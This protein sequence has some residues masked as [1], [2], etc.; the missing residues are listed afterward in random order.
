M[1]YGEETGNFRQ[2]GRMTDGVLLRSAMVKAAQKR[3][4][5]SIPSKFETTL[6]TGD[7]EKNAFGNRT[8]R[9]LNNETAVPGPG[10]YD[11]RPPP[12]VRNAQTCGSV[13]HRG[14]GGFASKSS[15]MGSD[16]SR[17]ELDD[18]TAPGPGEY[19]A[20][21]SSNGLLGKVDHRKHQNMGVFMKPFKQPLRGQGPI[22]ANAVPG[23]GEYTPN[24]KGPRMKREESRKSSNFKSGVDRFR[25]I[26]GKDREVPAPGSYNPETLH[27]QGLLYNPNSSFASGTKRGQIFYVGESGPTPGPGSYE[28]PAAYDAS[29]ADAGLATQNSSVFKNVAQDRFGRPYNRK[30]DYYDTPGPG[31]YSANLSVGSQTLAPAT[32]SSFVSK[33]TRDEATLRRRK[34]RAPGPAYYKPSVPS[35]QRKSFL[36]NSTQQWI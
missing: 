32:L 5:I 17:K 25:D 21:T 30:T 2:V 11:G 3:T 20:A 34:E 35:H 4:A 1:D 9:F 7:R 13:S 36:L 15:R 6:I 27:Q 14:Y 33:S 26:G 12:L 22:V 19:E 10:T 16:H 23:P 24:V 31:W 28:S 29:K 8:H 18:A